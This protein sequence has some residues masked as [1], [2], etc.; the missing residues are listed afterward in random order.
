MKLSTRMVIGWVAVIAG[1]LSLWFDA[2]PWYFL[3]ALLFSDVLRHGFRPSVP[4]SVARRRT[5]ILLPIAL[6][7][8]MLYT[9]LDVTDS[10]THPL[11]IIELVA[12]AAVVAWLIRDDIRVYRQLHENPA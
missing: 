7:V 5:W 9:L 2:A 1:C 4:R 3:G 10:P 6:A 8:L 11:R 12:L